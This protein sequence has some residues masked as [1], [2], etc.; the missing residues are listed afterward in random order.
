MPPAPAKII[1]RAPAPWWALALLILAV[2]L[3]YANSFAVPFVF[4]DQLA[5]VENPTLHSLA[6]AFSPPH[7]AGATVEGRPL[8]N[9]T[10]ALNY[11]ASGLG[12]WSYHAVNLA[13]HL[14]AALTLFGL[15]R[16][17]LPKIDSRLDDPIALAVVLLW[18][19]HPLQTE[20]VTYIAQRTESLM[21]L[22]FLATLYLFL[23]GTEAETK[24][25]T[26]P[27]T[28]SH[29][30]HW[31]AA[32]FITCLLG[33]ATK[34]VMVAAPVLVL[35]F[36]R[37]F[38]SGSWREAWRRH[39]GFH[40]ALAATWLLLA[41][42]VLGA[43][44]RGGTIG[45]SAGVAWWQYALTQSRAVLHYLR[46]AL[47][48]APLVFDYGPD[49]VTAGEAMPFLLLDVVLLGATLWALV[50]KP[51]AG[52]LGAWFF[53]ILAPTSSVVG[54]TRQMLAEHRMYLS[55]AAVAI[56]V[57]LLV[58]RFAGRRGVMAFASLATCALAFATSQRN[59]DYR[60]ELALW[61]DTVAKRPDNP[62]ARYNYGK[63]LAEAGQYEA[64]VA[65]DT[66]AI[67][68]RPGLVGAQVNLANA[69]GHLGRTA[70]AIPHYEAALQLKP[71]YA[72]AHFNLGNAL[73]QLDRKPEAAEHFRAAV[74]LDPQDAEARDNLGGVLL[75]LGDLPAAEKEFQEVL[76]LNPGLAETHCNLGTVYLLQGKPAAAIFEYEL[77]LKLNPQL[78]PA[79]AGLARAR[80]GSSP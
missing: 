9:A 10:L 17:V 56:A 64:A 43:G 58:H 13:I 47:W 79:R 19:V 71:D 67:R 49:F 48:P 40:L 65:Q 12:V 15:L 59:H 75:D 14:L 60:S 23:R 76:R 32:A 52:F 51:A 70:E 77:A 3:A 21:G 1:S 35:L 50:R 7:G 69:L 55:L 73:L 16:R 25:E 28:A 33:M 54:G 72:R 31:F 57:V 44:N 62:F 46:L 78:A 63:G 39:R 22:L 66:A 53:V 4:D 29:R 6:T 61:A 27:Q 45:A 42:L 30:H 2:V 5:V 80:S 74:R 37:T 34:E 20:S 18:A 8:F 26:A 38:V 24:A 41:A 11:A 36:D 68:L